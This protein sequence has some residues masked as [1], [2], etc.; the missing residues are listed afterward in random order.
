MAIVIIGGGAI[1]LLITGRLTQASHP[2]A[3]VARP[4]TVQAL[5]SAP[6]HI[7]HPPH[8]HTIPHIVAA[9]QPDT[10]PDAY[11]RP[12]LAILCI[13][14]YATT[15]ALPTLDALEPRHI[16]TLQNGLGNEEILAAHFGSDRVLSGI[17][18]SSVEPDTSNSITVTK[19]GGIG[20]APLS[21]SPDLSPHAQTFQ[22]AG[23]PTHTHPDYR[24]LKWS[25]TLLNI[26]GNATSA[27]LDMPV[28]ATYTN[29]AIVALERR[30]FL[31]GLS[32]MQRLNIAPINLPGYP[33]T[34]LARAMRSMP[35]PLLWQL[36]RRTIAGGRGG[37]A[38]SLQRDL[39]QGRTQSENDNLYGAIAHT[40]SE[41]DMHAPVNTALWYALN[42]IITG[43][44]PWE[45]FK[46]NPERLLALTGNP[47]T[48]SLT[49]EAPR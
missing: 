22:S 28:E 34:L 10:L 25:K 23:L 17:I 6:L 4:A 39:H 45:Y 20:L 49:K 5:G 21:G 1:G 2:T 29:R 19:A 11:H 35:F 40:A 26:L 3:L 12:D 27:I 48:P 37:K 15:S 7:Q 44:I 18:T 46:G 32:V 41:L 8:S 47:G 16:L 9:T 42:S 38:P 14:G 43:A 13:K 31:E 33:T 30:A 24:A 36:L